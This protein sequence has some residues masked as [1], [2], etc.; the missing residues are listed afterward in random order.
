MIVK[1]IK[2]L[3]S[4][5]F[6]HAMKQLILAL[7]LVLS[8]VSFVYAASPILLDTYVTPNEPRADEF[9]TITAVI[10]D[11]DLLWVKVYYSFDNGDHYNSAVMSQNNDY[12]SVQIHPIDKKVQV[13]YY[14]K[15]Q[16]QQDN[17]LKSQSYTFWFGG[18]ALKQEVFITYEEPIKYYRN[19]D[20]AF[21]ST[22][23]YAYKNVDG[24]DYPSGYAY[25]TTYNDYYDSPGYKDYHRIHGHK[26][27]YY[28]KQSYN[29]YY[30]TPYPTP[31]FKGYY[32]YY[33]PH[34]AYQHGYSYS[35]H[36]S[37]AA[38]WY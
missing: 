25:D 9:A 22:T 14:I 21:V 31:Y 5:S 17:T 7:I 2:F 20:G 15:A 30:W 29:N 24:Y 1:S 27:G 38:T 37:F 34:I 6:S 16:D 12:W 3:N 19:N 23:S 33:W 36:S 10:R 18:D 32:A 11:D 13:Q 35:A 26:R 8:S 28:P 4:K